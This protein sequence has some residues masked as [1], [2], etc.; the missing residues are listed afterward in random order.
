MEGGTERINPLL[1][2]VVCIFTHSQQLQQDHEVPQGRTREQKK[3]G[4]TLVAPRIDQSSPPF[5]VFMLAAPVACRCEKNGQSHHFH[6][7][8]HDHHA[9]SVADAAQAGRHVACKPPLYRER[10]L[11]V[12]LLGNHVWRQRFCSVRPP[13]PTHTRAVGAKAALMNNRVSGISPPFFLLPRGVEEK[14]ELSS[15]NRSLPP[16]SVRPGLTV[17]FF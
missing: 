6:H 1:P 2:T 11:A 14:T 5:K 10:S 15:L 3:R 4:G 12:R 7:H 13:P 9:R 17:Q 16:P 8:H